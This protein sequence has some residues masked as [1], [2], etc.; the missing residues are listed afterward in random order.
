MRA[1]L[2]I[3]DTWLENSDATTNEF[4]GRRN[5]LQICRNCYLQN[6]HAKLIQEVEAKQKGKAQSSTRCLLQVR[7]K[8]VSRGVLRYLAFIS[9]VSSALMH[10]G[11]QFRPGI[12]L[13]CHQAC[14][15]GKSEGPRFSHLCF[16]KCVIQLNRAGFRK[17]YNIY[18][19]F[20]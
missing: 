18:N 9:S 8:P 6:G 12:L 16:R 3:L 14:N 11:T 2:W 19:K 7:N 10:S 15:W 20:S 13:D 4:C 17:Y 5:E 1:L